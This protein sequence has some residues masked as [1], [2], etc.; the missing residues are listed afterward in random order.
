MLVYVSFNSNTVTT[1]FPA[2]VTFT[3]TWP[4]TPHW[5]CALPSL[6]ACGIISQQGAALSCPETQL[7]RDTRQ[8]K[9][10]CSRL[11]L[12]FSGFYFPLSVSLWR[13]S[14][15]WSFF[16]CRCVLVEKLKQ[17]WK[18]KGKSRFDVISADMTAWK[19][20]SKVLPKFFQM[21]LCIACQIM[22]SGNCSK[23]VF[24]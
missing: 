12:D 15:A 20:V 22:V 17:N 21:Y 7:R 19:H 10:E 4:W 18:Q 1:T 24:I 13:K 3:I 6:A 9:G 5:A 8:T 2:S 14:D 11:K 16:V 23:C